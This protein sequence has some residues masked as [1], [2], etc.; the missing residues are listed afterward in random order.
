MKMNKLQILNDPTKW[1]RT[2]EKA[3]GNL[4]LLENR[5]FEQIINVK[6]FMPT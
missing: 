2:L 6:T 3:G 1:L 5:S 4:N